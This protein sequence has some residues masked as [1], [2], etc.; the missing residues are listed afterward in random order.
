M[1]IRFVCPRCWTVRDGLDDSVLGKTIKCNECHGMSVAAHTPDPNEIRPAVKPRPPA[2]E[3]ETF[4]VLPFPQ[5]SGDAMPIL[6]TPGV[7]LSTGDI[8]GR[9][10][11]IDLVFAHASS[12]ESPLEGVPFA[13]V[14]TTVKGRLAQQAGQLGANAVIHIHF[15]FRTAKTVMELPRSFEVFASGTAVRILT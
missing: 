3:P 2:A 6:E 5:S 8:P 11:I 1:S 10:D 14:F 13:E 7:V 9:Y 12:N 4:A 15:D